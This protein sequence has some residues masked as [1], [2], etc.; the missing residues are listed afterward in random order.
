MDLNWED[1]TMQQLDLQALVA[2][3]TEEEVL[4][5]IKQMSC[6]KAPMASPVLSTSTTGKI[7]ST[8]S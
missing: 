8:T 3:I 4:A 2:K 6:D 1:L 7:L 5:T